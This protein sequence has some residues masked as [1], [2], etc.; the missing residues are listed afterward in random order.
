MESLWKK[1]TSLPRFEPLRGGIKTDVLIIG[2][3]MA[4][5]LCAHFLKEAGVDYAL[6]EAETICS[7]VTGSTTAKITSQHGLIYADLLRRF[8]EE[9][10]RLYYEVNQA[11]IEKYRRLCADMD[12]GFEE[13]DAYVYSLDGEEKLHRELEALERIGAEA[14]FAETLRLPFP[15]AGAVRFPHQAQFHPLRFAAAIA[16]G[17]TIYE[18]SP[19]R[20]LAPGTASTD[21]GRIRAENILV[22]THFP[23]LNRHGFYYLKMYQ[24]RSYA[25]AFTGAPDPGGMYLDESGKGLSFRSFGDKLILGGGAHRTGKPTGGW[26]S[27]EDFV[28]RNYPDAR[29]VCRW[30]AQDCMSLDGVPYIGPYSASTR[31]LYVATGFNK[32]GMTGSMVA[33]QLLTDLVLG[34]ENPYAELFSPSRTI[35]RPQLAVNGFEAVTGWLTPTAKRCPHLGCALKWNSQERSWDCPCHGSRF[36]E[37][38]KLLDNPATGDWKKAPKP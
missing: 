9:K 28:R 21:G 36:Q 20:E 24:N 17:L 35:L 30:A 13:K 8:G 16:E 32:W 11:A 23:F 4:G 33:A 38:G 27:I 2:G 25:A 10:A 26:S 18:H 19:V 14:S 15:T 22:C 34:R 12:G 1:E 3:G 5:L 29:E 7:G 6:V 31:G 37:N